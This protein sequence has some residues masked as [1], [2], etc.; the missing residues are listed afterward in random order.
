[1][2]DPRMDDWSRDDPSSDDRSSDDGMST[3]GA[4]AADV[5]RRS[6]TTAVNQGRDALIEAAIRSI[7]IDGAARTRP[8]ELAEDLGLSKSLVNFHFG[9]RDGLIA[10]AVATSYERYVD[11]V[12][13]AAESAGSDPVARLFAWI[14]EQI[15]WTMANP[16]IAAALNFPDAASGMLGRFDGPERERM[17]AAAARNHRN[18]TSLVT[19][20]RAHVRDPS[21]VDPDPTLASYDAVIVGWMTLGTAVWSAGG[22][23]PAAPP[24]LAAD[25]GPARRRMKEQIL[26]VLRAS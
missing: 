4:S 19:A 12:W 24:T 15:D 2:A 23:L 6:R 3:V 13:A 11:L 22:H 16:G 5:S 26:A 21:G 9:G 18:L 17:Q 8:K 7:S 1:M 20:A 10:E 14:D 25:L